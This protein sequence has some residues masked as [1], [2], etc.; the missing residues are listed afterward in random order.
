MPGRHSTQGRAAPAPQVPRSYVTRK[1]AVDSARPAAPVRASRSDV[2][3]SV[4]KVTLK[5]AMLGDAP[6]K[7]KAR[8]A[9]V[10]A[11]KTRPPQHAAVRAAAA[12]R[13]DLS[14]DEWDL[15]EVHAAPAEAQP[16][17]AE[18]LRPRAGRARAHLARKPRHRELC[19]ELAAGGG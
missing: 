5:L 13:D 19:T 10:A 9:A 2:E 15:E 18:G 11:Q 16:A 3:S 1:S 14:G 6:R 8:A 17:R 7:R 4:P 12:A